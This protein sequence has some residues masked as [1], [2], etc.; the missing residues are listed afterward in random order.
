VYYS[1]NPIPQTVDKKF[2]APAFARYVAVYSKAT[3]ATTKNL[4]R[5]YKGDG[6]ILS[7]K[8]LEVHGYETSKLKQLMIGIK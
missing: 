8:G 7:L 3:L 5:G 2:G 4:H 6:G 1:G